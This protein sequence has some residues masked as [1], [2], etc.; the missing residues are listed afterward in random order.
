MTYPTPAGVGRILQT[1]SAK[2]SFRHPQEKSETASR[3]FY[4]DEKAT[5]F[6]FKTRWALGAR[7][8]LRKDASADNQ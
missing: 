3:I 7:R 5:T 6:P 1:L 4:P 2:S 8:G